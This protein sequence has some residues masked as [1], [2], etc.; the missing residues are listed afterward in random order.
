MTIDGG[1]LRG[2]T[3]ELPVASAQVKTAIL[4][5]GLQADGVTTVREPSPSRDHTER[6][7]PAFGVDV[8][9]EGLAATVRGGARLRGT[10]V[11][12]PGDASSAAF[13]VVAALVL[14]DSEVRLDGVLLSPTRTAF[15]EVLRAMGG[16]VETHL[17]ASD[18][19]PIGSIVASSSELSGTT[20]DPELVPSL[21]DEVPALAVAGAFARGTFTIT[22]A[23]ELRVKESDRIAALAEGL[24]ALG[25]RVRERPDGLVV[26]GGAAL[27][28]ASVRSHGDHRIAMCL[29]V[30]ALA[31]AGR[32]EVEGASCVA[33]SF[34]EFYAVLDRA[35]GRGS[36]APAGSSWWGSWG[37]A[38]RRSAACSPASCATASR[39]WTSGSR[40]GP[41]RT[42]ARIF[43]EDGEEAF[44]ELERE[45]ALA[46]S[47]LPRR[48]VAT[49]GGAFTRLATREL[50]QQ[51]A[52][53]VW[54][55]CDLE[56]ILARI[57]ADGSRP[58]AA[59]RAIMP[60]LL[61]EREPSYRL[62]DVAV[63]ASAGTPRE[64][65]DR[66]VSM[67]EGRKRMRSSARQ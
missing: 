38:S 66:I 2:L 61:A 25:A 44:R 14:P 47:S 40:S 64:V 63:D 65:A 50:L 24:A 67:L 16:R 8:E 42:V 31:A 48:V 53:T 34:P 37:R 35:T 59:N 62:A 11:V 29:S 33:V 51:G 22:G 43:R 26:E 32:T 12:V 27:R 28:G 58:L 3:H 21:I 17:E 46:L 57:P 49:G 10:E 9:R 5:A 36:N 18:P 1:R 4:L 19:E 20:V 54:L 55:R 60:A 45:E 30:A 41:G 39:T 52:L 23:G 13:L 15:V 6:M 7:L 56:R